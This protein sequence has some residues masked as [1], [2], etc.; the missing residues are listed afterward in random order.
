MRAKTLKNLVHG[1]INKLT[2]ITNGEVSPDIG[3][4]IAKEHLDSRSNIHVHIGFNSEKYYAILD[5]N[6]EIGCFGN[7]TDCGYAD[8]FPQGAS[9][10]NEVPVFIRVTEDLE[11]PEILPVV[12]FSRTVARLKH[13]DNGNY[14]VGHPLSLL[15]F[16]L[17]YVEI[18]LKIGNSFLWVGVFPSDKTSCQMRWSREQRKL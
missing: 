4:S 1:N 11:I 6:I 9:A 12:I 5:R 14:R 10:Q 8:G 17:S 2:N 13:I 7:G 18:S 16:F 3:R 15:P